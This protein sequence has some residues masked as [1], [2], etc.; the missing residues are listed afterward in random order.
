MSGWSAVLDKGSY[1]ADGLVIAGAKDNDVSS[2]RVV[3]ASA[4]DE[5]ELKAKPG[6]LTP[7]PPPPR[8]ASELYTDPLAE[9][10]RAK[11]RTAD[12]NL[13]QAEAEIAELDSKL[14]DNHDPAYGALRGKCFRMQKQQYNYEVCPFD[15]VNQGHTSLGRWENFDE[16]GHMLFKNGQSCWQGPARSAKVELE[17]G[18]ENQVYYADEPEVC[19]YLIKMKTPAACTEKEEARLKAEIASEGNLHDEV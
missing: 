18:T 6:D 11:Y 13:R 1:D 8:P 3:D 9:E 7:P 10:A 2:L 16:D 19:T 4:T 12:E 5:N 14:Q 17:C 15:K